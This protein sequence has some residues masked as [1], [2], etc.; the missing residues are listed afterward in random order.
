MLFGSKKNPYQ[1]Y[2]DQLFDFY[3]QHIP[4]KT[5]VALAISGGPDSVVLMES[6]LLFWEQEKRNF[7]DLHF[8]HCHHNI[9]AE[10]DTEAGYLQKR[11][12]D[13]NFHYFLR[14]PE[15]K[16]T[17]EALR[18]WRYSCFQAVCKKEK[19]P[20]LLLG[21]N[22][23]D[24]VEGSL[25]HLIRGCG[26][27]G[28]LNMREHSD[29]PLLVE[30]KVLRPLLRISK[31]LIS[32][33][34]EKQG[35][36]FF[37]D[38]SNE[39]PEISLRNQIRIQHLFPLAQLGNTTTQGEQ[40]FFE[41]WDTVYQ[42]IQQHLAW[43]PLL[44]VLKANP[45]WGSSNALEWIVPNHQTIEQTEIAATL[46]YLGIKPKKRLLKNLQSHLHKIKD[47]ERY[48]DGWNLVISQ[49]RIYLIQ[50][51]KKFW[52]KKIDL[53]KEINEVGKQTF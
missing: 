14:D 53:E 44:Q 6:I 43:T 31:P 34:A 1:N 2:L 37:L 19:I 23:S 29:H 22:L 11:L 38:Q 15:S 10:S 51:K 8:I 42:S 48:L 41:S 33:L 27:E 36:T 49:G 40:I 24:R 18:E 46:T 26:I 25:M 30:T 32:T 50:G 12:I 4:P 21:H 3:Q 17:E 28:F 35:W 20:F 5:K 16:E 52:E 47:A 39:N 9:R 13:F 45:Y 7:R